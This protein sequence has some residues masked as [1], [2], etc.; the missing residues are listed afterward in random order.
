MR[1]LFEGGAYLSNWN[2]QLKSLLHLGQIVITF[3]TL[4]HL[5]PFITFRPSAWS[6]ILVHN[7]FFFLQNSRFKK[8]FDIRFSYKYCNLTSSCLPVKMA[9]K[10]VMNKVYCAQC[11]N[12]E[13]YVPLT[14]TCAI[15]ASFVD[16]T[17]NTKTER[18]RN[19]LFRVNP[20]HN[21]EAV[22][23]EC[24]LLHYLRELLAS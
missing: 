6:F 2:W 19:E 4:L 13:L 5:G 1:R 17:K 14:V 22:V 15:D 24:T 11:E 8:L 16:R 18:N 21:L 7:S 23:S 20:D 9:S 3:R 12:G 10:T